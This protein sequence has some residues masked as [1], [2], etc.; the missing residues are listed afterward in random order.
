MRNSYQSKENALAKDLVSVGFDYNNVRLG[1]D[2]NNTYST[3]DKGRPSVRLTS[4]DVFTHGLFI[5][6]IYHMPASTCGTWPACSS[7]L[8]PFAAA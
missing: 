1:V 6:D 7:L 4:H 5:A 3:S 8:L 2:S